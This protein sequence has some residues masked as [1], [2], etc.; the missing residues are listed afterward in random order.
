[1]YQRKIGDATES[2]GT[3]T[4]SGRDHRNGKPA[5]PRTSNTITN[6]N[7]NG[8]YSKQVRMTLFRNQTR[9]KYTAIKPRKLATFCLV[10]LIGV[11]T[12]VG[13]RMAMESTNGDA[14]HAGGN[15]YRRH[16]EEENDD[17][18]DDGYDQPGLPKSLRNGNGHERDRKLHGEESHG[19][20][21]MDAADGFR[22]VSEGAPECRE[23]G[24]PDE[25]TVTLV[26]QVSHDRLWMLEHHCDRYRYRNRNRN[27]R[28]GGGGGGGRFDQHPMSIAV[29]SN[30]TVDTVRAELRGMG[31]GVAT[32]AADGNE[33]ENAPVQVSVL[34][35]RT[36]GAWDNFPVNELRNLAL[37]KVRTTHILYIDVDF[38][39][40]DN[41]YETIM[42]GGGVGVVDKTKDGP[43]PSD[44]IRRELFD[45]PKLALVIPAFQ[46]WRQC[47][48]WEDCREDNLPH[49]ESART[50]EGL[51]HEITEH[52]SISVFDPTN[53]GGHGSTNYRVWFT[54]EQ[55]SLY[56]IECLQSNRY[57]P[58]VMVRYCRDLPP[59][60]TAFAGYGK[61]KVTWMMQV[62]AEGYVFSQV[63]GVHLVHYPHLDSAS[64]QTWNGGVRKTDSPRR[65]QDSKRGRIDAL[66]V[67]FKAWLGATIPAGARR[68][69]LCGDAQDDDSKLWAE[70]KASPKK[71]AVASGGV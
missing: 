60:Q 35:G 55:G 8:K 71:R 54:Q 63:G 51:L 53:K 68:L 31:C 9:K 16:E 34:D 37:S 13:A 7:G 30:A 44:V 52:K 3:Q 41:L 66:F 57:E 50:F 26:T 22:L 14:G 42:G 33:N 11:L 45:D 12:F 61:N 28:R 58:F 70:P 56:D 47:K 62:V 48:E 17:G 27:R 23:L 29:Y 1:M 21:K 10:F 32:A 5:S 40:S 39:P 25:I 38:W 59:F 36:H 43:S 15:S 19:R 24:S 49:M 2:R 64:R 65:K 67:A 20:E 4:T 69:E 6:G 46:L 18:Y